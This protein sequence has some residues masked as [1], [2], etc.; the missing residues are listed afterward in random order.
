MILA[1]HRP[2]ALDTVPARDVIDAMDALLA[3]RALWLDRI[4]AIR[5]AEPDSEGIKHYDRHHEFF[6]RSEEEEVE[7]GEE[8]TVEENMA[9]LY[10]LADMVDR[11]NQT[12][13]SRA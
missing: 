6:G 3:D 12:G 4:N 10:H 13:L 5:G 2:G 7:E 8:P 1:G 9:N 11:V